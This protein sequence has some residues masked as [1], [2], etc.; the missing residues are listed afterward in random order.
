[1][2]KH[3][4][5]SR[6]KAGAYLAAAGILAL[7]SSAG[8]V[9]AFQVPPGVSSQ[10]INASNITPP[11][12]EIPAAGAIVLATERPDDVT[13][14]K[15][16]TA[17]FTQAYNAGDAEG[18]AN[19]FTENARIIDEA[20]R[21]T[22]GRAAIAAL[23]KRSFTER[24]G[25]VMAVTPE[26]IRFLGPDTAIEEGTAN[27]RIPAIEGTATDVET[28]RYTVVY[29]KRGGSWYQA[30]VRDHAS[31]GSTDPAD[32]GTS[33]YVHLRPLEWLIG[34]WVEEG[35]DVVMTSSFAWSDNRNFLIRTFS[36]KVPGR[37]PL[38][39]TQ[40]I[41]WDPS[42]RQIRSWEFDSDGSFGEGIWNRRNDNEWVIK[43]NGV[44]HDG[45]IASDTRIVTRN[46][47]D[48]LSWKAVDRTISGEVQDD[49]PLFAMVRSAPA[50]GE[51]KI[52]R[53][54]Q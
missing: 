9:L 41:G 53:A 50:P 10:P 5:S 11:A 33:N 26:S 32:D 18:A 46:G 2:R 35:T 4:K 37:P 48:Q 24:A 45:R 3:E 39:G 13:A 43:M 23:F 30:S 36:L 20:G 17:T 22:E 47:V 8:L 42:T 51:A 29:V 15:A 38:T 27:T 6:K 14:L 12:S 34:D 52:K 25:E 40:R 54:T 49:S 7:A 16:L 21:L 31:S 28:S 19:T 1:M 44:R